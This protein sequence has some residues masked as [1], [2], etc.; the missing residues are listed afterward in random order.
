MTGWNQ[1]LSRWGLGFRHLPNLGFL[2]IQEGCCWG[3]PLDIAGVYLGLLPDLRG[4]FAGFL[5]WDTAGFAMGRRCILPGGL[6]GIPGILLRL[7]LVPSG[8][9]PWVHPSCIF[10][11]APMQPLGKMGQFI[12]N[13]ADSWQLRE[14]HRRE[15]CDIM[16]MLGRFR[17]RRRIC[18]PRKVRSGKK[19][20][21]SLPTV[22]GK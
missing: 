13:R 3:L 19:A 21:Q 5:P 11:I 2:R 4:C 8:V 1:G 18:A 9:L 16:V 15:S 7:T 10:I 20:S 17:N 22:V 6:L 14:L 12:K